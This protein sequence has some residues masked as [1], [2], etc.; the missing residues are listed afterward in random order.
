ME[1]REIPD[2]RRPLSL[3]AEKMILRRES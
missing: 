2:K 1:R 3:G